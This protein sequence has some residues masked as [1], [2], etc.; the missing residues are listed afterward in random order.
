MRG[1]LALRKRDA[2]MAGDVEARVREAFRQ[3]AEGEFHV[4]QRLAFGARQLTLIQS[5]S[6]PF[7]ESGPAAMDAGAGTTDCDEE[8]P[9]WP[10]EMK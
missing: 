7:T 4:R 2:A 10:W 9:T 5:L 8:P 6:D 1:G 3:P